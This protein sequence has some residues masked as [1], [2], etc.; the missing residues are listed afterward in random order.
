MILVFA[1]STTKINSENGVIS[2]MLK[3]TIGFP[4]VGEEKAEPDKYFGDKVNN[5]I[6]NIST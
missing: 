6:H 3:L 2:T 1:H 4:L 5:F